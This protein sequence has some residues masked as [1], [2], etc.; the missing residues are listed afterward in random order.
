MCM[1]QK[2][3]LCPL[4]EECYSML[5]PLTFFELTGVELTTLDLQA[6]YH[7]GHDTSPLCVCVC[8][9]VCVFVCVYFDRV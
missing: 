8:V 5:C 4:K 6:F 3:L 9:C 7:L 2:C 1:S